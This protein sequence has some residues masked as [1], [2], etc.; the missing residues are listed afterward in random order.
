MLLPS[1]MGWCSSTSP[2]T[3]MRG[4]TASPWLHHRLQGY[5]SSGIWSSFIL[6]WP[7]CLQGCSSYLF[8]P[9]SSLD[10]ITSVTFFLLKSVIIEVIG[11]A[12]ASCLGA[13]WD[14][15]CQKLLKDATP[16]APMLSKPGHSNPKCRAIDIWQEVPVFRYLHLCVYILARAAKSHRLS[17]LQNLS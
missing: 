16:V 6:H 5:L 3:P 10:T 14:W 7:W 8:S 4:T 13:D 17:H 15:L 2:W 12:S 11:P 1:S 9:H